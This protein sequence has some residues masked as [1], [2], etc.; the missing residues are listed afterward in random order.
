MARTL[1]GNPPALSSGKVA[2]CWAVK[3]SYMIRSQ[4]PLTEDTS[5]KPSPVHAIDSTTPEHLPCD[6]M[7]QLDH[8]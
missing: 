2:H 5:R 1:S 3:A 8:W 4:L 6:A 7:S